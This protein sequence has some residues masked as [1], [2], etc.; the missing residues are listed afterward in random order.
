MSTDDAV[1]PAGNFIGREV[2]SIVKAMFARNETDD[3][4]LDEA[5]D[6]VEREAAALALDALAAEV[7]SHR[8]EGND[9]AVGYCTGKLHSMD[10]VLRLIDEAK[11]R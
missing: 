10:T 3:D 4:I 1:T 5:F 9:K 7:R 8:C 6:A 11:A 2:R